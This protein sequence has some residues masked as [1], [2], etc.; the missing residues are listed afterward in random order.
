MYRESEKLTDTSHHHSASA[1]DEFSTLRAVH[2]HLRGERLQSHVPV[3]ERLTRTDP[4]R[5]LQRGLE[6][7]A[8][9]L[10]LGASS[11]GRARGESG[12]AQLRGTS[13][14][15]AALRA[16]RTSETAA[17][18]THAIERHTL[19]HAA[20]GPRVGG[21][22]AWAHL[23]EAWGAAGER[24]PQLI[25]A[26]ALQLAVDV[27]SAS[28]RAHEAGCPSADARAQA[29]E[30]ERASAQAPQSTLR[31]TCTVAPPKPPPQRHLGASNWTD[32]P[33][34]CEDNCNSGPIK[35]EKSKS[36]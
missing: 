14:A 21:G 28:A 32:V 1:R 33:R 22:E 19:R 17:K 11:A 6:R 12:G 30:E 9:R 3:V 7:C 10:H 23:G 31:S 4:T 36:K 34:E 5:A 8:H 26:C 16:R 20:F 18:P 25:C 29:R 35:Q 15:R 24:G 2:R 27:C 13:T